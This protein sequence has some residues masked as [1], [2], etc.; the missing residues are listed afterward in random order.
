MSLS[1][2][3]V[4]EKLGYKRREAQLYIAAL[5]L[6]EAKVSDL[7]EKLKIPRTSAIVIAEKLH[8][9]GLLNYYV[10]CFNKYWV[11]EN[12][13]NLLL[14]LK[15]NETTLQAVL[16]KLKALQSNV[17]SGKPTARTYVGAKELKFIFEDI[18]LAKKNFRAI[19]AWNDLN[20]LFGARYISDFIERYVGHFLRFQLLAPESPQTR[21]LK[22]S[23]AKES[24]ETRLLPKHTISLNTATFMYGNKI[25]LVSL[26]ETLPTGFLIEDSDLSH[27]MGLFFEELWSHNL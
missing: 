1:I 9:E 27:T 4:I 24:R 25:A 7:A 19:I 8:K 2:Q 10:K 12:P 22:E 20:M 3:Q 14:K 18:I 13:D 26:N 21:S 11:A 15:E 17:S 23:D 5:V 6:G 16:P